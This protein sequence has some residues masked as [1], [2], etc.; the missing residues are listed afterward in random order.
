MD[1]LNRG[2]K[3]RDR[4]GK[5]HTV[6]RQDDNTVYTYT[7]GAEWIHRSNCWRVK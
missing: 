3:I 4:Y 1:K 2:D 5:I 7:C 6:L